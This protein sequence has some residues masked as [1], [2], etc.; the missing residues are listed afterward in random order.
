M[1]RISDHALRDGCDRA[2]DLFL[3]SRLR[4]HDEA[5]AGLAATYEALGLDAEMRED[6]RAALADLVPVKGVPAIEGMIVS[7]ML[8]GALVGL[9]IADSELPAEELGLPVAPPR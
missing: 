4:G 5:A 3:L 9:L 2:H 6:L 1:I 7:S 8:A